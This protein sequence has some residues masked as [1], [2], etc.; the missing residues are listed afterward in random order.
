[1]LSLFEV[2]ISFLISIGTESG[3]TTV[4]SLVTVS[5][6]IADISIFSC[7]SGGYIVK[8]YIFKQIKISIF[9]KF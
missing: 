6:I 4:I 7:Y 9:K 1:M 2:N 8:F 3:L 5:R